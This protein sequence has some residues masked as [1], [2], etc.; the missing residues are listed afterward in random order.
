M[1][2]KFWNCPPAEQ[3]EVKSWYRGETGH[4]L[5]T[6]QKEP[7]AALEGRKVD[8]AL[9]KHQENHYKDQPLVFKFQAKKFFSDQAS[10]QICKGVS[11]NKST[12]TPAWR[13]SKGCDGEGASG[14]D[15]Y[16][17]APEEETHCLD[18]T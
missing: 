3:G 5:Y 11:I 18:T 2:N 6:R 4:T 13:S 14:V 9:Y 7:T 1:S 12:L 10:K 17:S 8:I 16:V 15:L